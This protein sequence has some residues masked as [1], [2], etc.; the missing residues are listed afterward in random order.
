VLDALALTSGGLVEWILD[1]KKGG[2]LPE[3]TTERA[4]PTQSSSY[5]I[6]LG[7]HSPNAALLAAGSI[8][9]LQAV[10]VLGQ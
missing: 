10:D 4:N 9:A 1:Y 2:K 8:I 6:S 3:K 7:P 5:Q